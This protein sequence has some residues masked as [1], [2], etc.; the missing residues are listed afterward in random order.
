METDHRS[1]GHR[2]VD[3]NKT[4]HFA[5]PFENVFAFWTTYAEFPRYT[6][7]MREVLEQGEGRSRWRVIGPM[8]IETMWNAVITK[9]VADR[10]IAW[11]TEP[12]SLIQHAWTLKFHDNGDGTTTMHLKMTYNPLAGI[13]GHGVASLVGNDL[14]ALL[15]EDLLRIKTVLDETVIP[16]DVQQRIPQPIF[17]TEQVE[18]YTTD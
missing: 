6:A 7:H 17:K 14:K 18:R 1:G 12:D 3:V 4:V 2:A 8:E 5:A 11:R 10:E 9:F 13:I 15:E 16:R